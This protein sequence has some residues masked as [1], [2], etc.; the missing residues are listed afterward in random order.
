MIAAMNV[1]ASSSRMSQ[2][3][4]ASSDME[5]PPRGHSLCGSPRG[6]LAA[7]R[8]PCP[9]LRFVTSS[10][11][12]PAAPA[13]WSGL[14]CRSAHHLLIEPAA[15]LVALGRASDVG[16]AVAAGVA[17]PGLALARGVP[18][19][20]GRARGQAGRRAL[21]MAPSEQVRASFPG[22]SR[23]RERPHELLLHVALDGA[24]AGRADER[25]R[26]RG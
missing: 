14:R 12:P 17:E 19:S 26:Q 6:D 11:R 13:P 10:T 21:K 22:V 23:L 15:R 18:G 20:E 7:A 8:T 5:M 25:E 24:V 3:P 16:P 1:V 4:F 2:S 9:P